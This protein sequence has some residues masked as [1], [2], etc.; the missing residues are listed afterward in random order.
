MLESGGCVRSGVDFDIESY[1]PALVGAG[2]LTGMF[3]RTGTTMKLPTVL[4]VVTAFVMAVPL[5]G[6]IAAVTLDDSSVTVAYLRMPRFDTKK[7]ATFF[8]LDKP[9]IGGFSGAPVYLMPGPFTSGGTLVVR[10][11]SAGAHVV[12]LVH[13]TIGDNTGGKLA[14]IVPAKFIHDTIVEADRQA[15]AS[16]R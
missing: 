10:A 5:D 4:M 1:R 2:L 7:E 3:S 16:S 6:G 12:G 9:S 8:L 11:V 14:A 15:N 13:G